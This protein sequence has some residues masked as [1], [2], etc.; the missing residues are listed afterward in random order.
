LAWVCIA[1]IAGVL[2]EESPSSGA[3]GGS[4]HTVGG[5]G[6]KPGSWGSGRHSQR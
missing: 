2:N 5:G 3:G 1:V 4:I 6:K